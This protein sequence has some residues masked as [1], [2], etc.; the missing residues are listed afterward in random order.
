MNETIEKIINPI[1]RKEYTVDEYIYGKWDNIKWAFHIFRNKNFIKKNNLL[2]FSFFL[3]KQVDEV[4]AYSRGEKNFKNKAYQ[5]KLDSYFM[6]I[7]TIINKLKQS[8]L[9]I[10]LRMY[11]DITTAKILEKYLD[12]DFVEL[13][14][15][16]FPQFFDF[17]KMCHYGFFGTLVRYIPFFK[18]KYHNDNEWKTT[19]V[20]DIDTNFINEFKLLEYFFDLMNK[21]TNLPNIFYRNRLCYYLLSRLNFL[22][23]DP[24]YFSIISNFVLQRNPIDIKIFTD[25]LQNCVLQPCEDYEKVVKKYLPINLSKQPMGGRLEFGVDEFFMNEFF[26]KGYYYKNNLDI[27]LNTVGDCGGG[28]TDWIFYLIMNHVKLDKP[29]LVEQFLK[30]FIS[31]FFPPNYQIPEYSS[32][33]DLINIIDKYMYKKDKGKKYQFYRVIQEKEKY[34]KLIEIIRKIGPEN[35]NMN[36]KIYYCI[37][38]TAIAE[39][40]AIVIKIVKPNPKYPAFKEEHIKTIQFNTF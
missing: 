32:V 26:L 16:F 34:D 8:N 22:D 12:L 33:Y 3:L 39:P 21:E 18:L 31:L 17:N 35:L 13:Y 7:N 25:F 30:V 28:I 23:I 24:P 10:N 9:D 4:Y 29:E 15:Y 38:K 37:E 40:E 19:T 5:K 1:E 27:M 11:C 36:P 6:G 14:I 20:V 2:V